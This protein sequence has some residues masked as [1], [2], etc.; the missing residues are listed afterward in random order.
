MLR[1]ALL[2][3]VPVN[4]QAFQRAA[5]DPQ[6]EWLRR[7][8]TEPERHWREG[9]ADDVASPIARLAQDAR[10]LGVQVV[11]DARLADLGRATRECDA[12]IVMAH[13]KG[14]AV[15]ADDLIEFRASV[16]AN[17]LAQ[18][19]ATAE[20]AASVLQASSTAQASALLQAHVKSGS[21]AGA[22]AG[23]FTV[24]AHEGTVAALRRNALDAVLSGLLRPGNRLEL[25]DGLFDAGTVEAAIAS[26]F[27]G[28]LDLSSCQARSLADHIDRQ[29]LGAC[30]VVQFEGDL[31]PEVAALAILRTLQHCASGAPDYLAA[32][33]QALDELS[34]ALQQETQ[35]NAWDR[36]WARVW[37]L[38][39]RASLT[40][41][42]R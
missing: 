42:R 19:G 3:A 25:G 31:M 11:A 8:A 16:L 40:L 36:A 2:L 22:V 1:L 4:W 26:G 17:R 29:R 28:V 33:Q 6:R 23:E 5:Y 20:L 39:R 24:L 27:T 38:V 35:R 10:A 15:G 12:V 13:W 41:R 18:H 37:D 21:A 30:G 32:R 14:P 9:Y 34:Q 7:F